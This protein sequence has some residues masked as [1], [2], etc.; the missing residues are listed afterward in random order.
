MFGKKQRVSEFFVLYDDRD[1]Q[2]DKIAHVTSLGN[3]REVARQ[4]K[5]LGYKTITTAARLGPGS[6]F[7]LVNVGHLQV[8]DLLCDQTAGVVSID[9]IEDAGA[10]LQISGHTDRLTNVERLI[11]KDSPV[12]VPS[13]TFARIGNTLGSRRAT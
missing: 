6:I 5:H 8:G 3:W 11:E 1:G 4:F 13:I 12:P 9:K 10:A 2:G 7:P